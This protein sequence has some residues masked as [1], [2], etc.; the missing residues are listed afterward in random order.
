MTR[1]PRRSYRYGYDSSTEGYRFPLGP[2]RNRNRCSFTGG[3]DMNRYLNG[4]LVPIW[5]SDAGIRW[6]RISSEPTATGHR[7]EIA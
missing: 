7:V 4:Y 6:N 3:I 5:R 1:S 2:S